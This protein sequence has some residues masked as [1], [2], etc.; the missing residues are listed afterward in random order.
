MP[1]RYTDIR[2]DIA[3]HPLLALI[4][5]RRLLRRLPG[6]VR[7]PAVGAAVAGRLPE[8]L[9]RLQNALQCIAGWSSQPGPGLEVTFPDGRLAYCV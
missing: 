6:G 4:R 7:V 3:A 9:I 8:G 5:E 1:L 2:E